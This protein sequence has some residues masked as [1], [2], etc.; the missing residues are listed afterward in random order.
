MKSSL[1]NGKLVSPTSLAAAKE[2]HQQFVYEIGQVSAQLRDKHRVEKLGVE[3]YA[4]WAA[5]A[6][7]AN[8][9]MEK[10]AEQLAIWINSQPGVKVFREAAKLLL[11]LREEVDLDPEEQA[12]VHRVEVR[13]RLTPARPAKKK[14]KLKK[15]KKK[16]KGHGKETK[17]R[18]AAGAAETGRRVAGREGASERDCG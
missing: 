11:R 10:D 17:A 13:L 14:R 3:N 8:S 4:R 7:S 5:R 1:R 6:R 12:L 9:Y 18:P 15:L 2:R 16:G